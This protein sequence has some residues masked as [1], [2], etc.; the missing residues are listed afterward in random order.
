MGT[1]QSIRS[2]SARRTEECNRGIDLIRCQPLR[3]RDLVVDLYNAAQAIDQLP[4][5]A[6]VSVE[7]VSLQYCFQQYTAV[8]VH[9]MIRY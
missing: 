6:S 2:S 3:G 5:F 9:A 7:H 8:L 4:Y 1:S